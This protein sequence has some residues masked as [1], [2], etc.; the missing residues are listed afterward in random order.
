M[1]S[2]TSKIASK[3]ASKI[4]GKTASKIA[5][6]TASKIADKTASKIA[7]KTASKIA[8]KTASKIVKIFKFIKYPLFIVLI[9]AFILGLM[10]LSQSLPKKTNDKKN[11]LNVTITETFKNGC[12][13][14]KSLSERNVWCNTLNDMPCKTNDCCVLL[15]DVDNKK[16]CTGG[17]IGGPTYSTDYE[18]YNHKQKCY[19]KGSKMK[20]DCPK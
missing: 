19:S 17:D 3:T 6:K 2:V 12:S 4:A 5:S 1:N 16:K 9:V 7:D 8:G 10:V 14:S 15:S 18:Y 20:I 11:P 13:S